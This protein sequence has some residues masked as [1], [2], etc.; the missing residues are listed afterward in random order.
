MGLGLFSDRSLTRENVTTASRI[1]LPAYALHMWGFGLIYLLDPGGRLE[2]S[3]GLTAARFIGLPFH[4]WGLM[5]LMVAIVL[6]I[7]L[8][9]HYRQIA[10]WG[11]YCFATICL[12]WAAIYG[13]S[14]YLNPDTSLAGSI[15][16]GTLVAACHATARSLSQGDRS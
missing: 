3:P 1:M 2:R 11:L 9:G 4:V 6:T 8:L 10:I 15:W 13:C 14:A 12:W 16:P 7:A 5:I